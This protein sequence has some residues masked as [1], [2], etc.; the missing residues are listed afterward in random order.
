ML[1]LAGLGAIV[2][3]AWKLDQ[4]GVKAEL[5]LG[6]AGFGLWTLLSR[7]VAPVGV[8]FVFWSNL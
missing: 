2:F 3:A 6:D 5:G 1:P 8:L 4:Q 7:Y